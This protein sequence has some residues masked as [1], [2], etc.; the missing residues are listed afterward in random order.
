MRLAKLLSRRYF[1]G[2]AIFLIWSF[3]RKYATVPIADINILSITLSVASILFGFM[4]GFFITELWTRYADIRTNQALWVANILNMI[5]H[6]KSLFSRNAKFEKE[7]IKKMDRDLVSNIGLESWEALDSELKYM[8]DVKDTLRHVKLSDKL[9][10][11]Y[12]DKFLSACD[13]AIIATQRQILLVKEK[14]FISEWMILIGL[15]SIILVSASVI[16]YA[17]LILNVLLHGLVLVVVLALIIVYELDRL[18]WSEMF[19][20]AEPLEKCFDLLG[21]KRFY[22]DRWLSSKPD[23]VKEYRTYKTL[24]ADLKKVLKDVQGSPYTKRGLK[25]LVK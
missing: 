7:F 24:S 10:E 18:L 6:A 21:V 3:S 16:Q 19:I 12:A 5:H 2:L 25:V 11:R 8:I 23:E 20:I 15:T 13:A 22:P 9:D 4:A 17:S 1:I 14:L